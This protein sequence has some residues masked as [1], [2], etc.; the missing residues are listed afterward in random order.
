MVRDLTD[1]GY[2]RTNTWI[3][4]SSQKRLNPNFSSWNVDL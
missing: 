3:I 4:P 1:N 2:M